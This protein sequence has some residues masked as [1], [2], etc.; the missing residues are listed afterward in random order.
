M[1]RSDNLFRDLKL[2]KEEAQIEKAIET[3]VYEEVK[4]VTELR[5]AYQ[6]V[7]KRKKRGGSL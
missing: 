5:K 3:G 1:T 7:A 6:Q 2:T 4:D